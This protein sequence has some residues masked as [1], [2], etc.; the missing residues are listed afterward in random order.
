M[1]RAST[2]ATLL[3]MCW[4]AQQAHAQA[5][6]FEGQDLQAAV[7]QME[8]T[9]LDGRRWTA[10]DLKGRIVLIDFWATWCA[11]C[12][13]QIPELKRMRAKFADRFEVLA[14]SVDSRTRR[15]LIAWLNQREVD[16]PQVHDGRAFSSP[17]V[18]RFGVVALPASVLL[19]DG[20]IAAFN[21]RG[22]ALEEAVAYLTSTSNFDAARVP[23]VMR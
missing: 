1:R 14:I 4:S 23:I 8:V 20:R 10:A 19:V 13:T 7:N 11:P 5:P 17:V 12:L 18:R 15:D 21:L 16:W 6:F 3:V 9:D 22:R 2:I